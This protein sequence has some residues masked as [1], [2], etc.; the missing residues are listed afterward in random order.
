MP[1]GFISPRD[2]RLEVTGAVSMPPIRMLWN[3]DR[4]P[5]SLARDDPFGLSSA[6]P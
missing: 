4:A 6:E 3:R 2:S 5:Q 1:E